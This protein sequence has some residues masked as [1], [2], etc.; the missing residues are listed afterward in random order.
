MSYTLKQH[1]RQSI[2][3]KLSK[4]LKVDKKDVP[5]NLKKFKREIEEMEA[6]IRN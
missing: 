4:I 3:R 1:N 6:S 2:L 5:A